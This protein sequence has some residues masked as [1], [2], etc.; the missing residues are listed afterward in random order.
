M[1]KRIGVAY[2]FFACSAKPAEVKNELGDIRRTVKTPVE[3]ETILTHRPA[4]DETDARICMIHAEAK[5]NT[6]DYMLTVRFPGQSNK[7]ACEEARAIMNQA[8][9]SPLY[10]E[11]DPF[12]GM[13]VFKS[14]RGYSIERAGF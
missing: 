5:L 12:K 14:G 6:L 13:L 1:A 4:R 8:Y 3:V 7:N 11:N 2:A 9:Q 10:G